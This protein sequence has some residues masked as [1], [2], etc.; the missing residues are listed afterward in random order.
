MT[1]KEMIKNKNKCFFQRQQEKNDD[2]ILYSFGLVLSLSLHSL[3]DV[4]SLSLV[5][6]SSSLSCFFAL[7]LLPQSINFTLV[8]MGFELSALVSNKRTESTASRVGA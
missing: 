4:S 8:F 3:Y 5:E 2:L 1:K 7:S 6:K